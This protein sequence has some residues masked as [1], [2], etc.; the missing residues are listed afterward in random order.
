MKIEQ[1]SF[2][3]AAFNKK[4]KRPLVRGRRENYCSSSPFPREVT[5]DEIKSM[6]EAFRKA[7]KALLF[8]QSVESNEFEPCQLFEA[9]CSRLKEK[10]SEVS[11]P[12][13]LSTVAP[14]VMLLDQIF[15]NVRSALDSQLF[16]EDQLKLVE[17]SA[18]I[19]VDKAKEICFSTMQ[20]SQDLHWYVK[21]SGPEG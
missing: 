1:L 6:A 7:N 2:E 10:N 4:S 11:V 20:Q 5:K 8:C 21:L 18:M 17:N 9:S 14:E 12:G 16:T 15:T 19:T 13:S 3:K